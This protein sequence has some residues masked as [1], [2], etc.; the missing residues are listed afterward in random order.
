MIGSYYLSMLDL[1]QLIRISRRIG[2]EVSTYI[3]EEY[4]LNE[5]CM[6]NIIERIKYT[7]QYKKKLSCSHIINYN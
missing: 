7:A 3:W 2:N 1:L 5:D 6:T 4:S